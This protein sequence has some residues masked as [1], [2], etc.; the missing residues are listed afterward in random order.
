V[1][2]PFLSKLVVYHVSASRSVHYRNSRFAMCV[3]IFGPTVFT[4]FFFPDS[5]LSPV[6]EVASSPHGPCHTLFPLF[7]P[8]HSHR[9]PDRFFW[10]GLVVSP[11]QH[12]LFLSSHGP[13]HARRARPVFSFPLSSG[14]CP[15][16]VLLLN[17]IFSVVEVLLYS[18]NILP[19][20]VRST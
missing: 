1:R 9:T 19:V 3:P 17:V 13:Y 10:L 8:V 12:M 20:R 4:L 18:D 7:P 16:Y 11:V 5:Y 6:K 15:L 2:D 14:P